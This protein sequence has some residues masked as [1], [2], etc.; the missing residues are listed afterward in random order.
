MSIQSLLS[1]FWPF[2]GKTEH[3]QEPTKQYIHP[4]YDVE[5]IKALIYLYG[6]KD[7]VVVSFVGRLSRNYVPYGLMALPSFNITASQM[8]REA[9]EK[10][11]ILSDHGDYY[12]VQNI[13]KVEVQKSVLILE[14][15]YYAV[16]M[17]NEPTPDH[18]PDCSAL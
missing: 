8:L 18:S 1:K 9:L 6:K 3:T 16:E 12:A 15:Q 7:P 13:R 4:K 11:F 17:P 5:S 2:G 10:K 14:D